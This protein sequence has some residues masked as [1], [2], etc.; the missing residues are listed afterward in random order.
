MMAAWCLN[1]AARL[2]DSFLK[3]HP[4]QLKSILA[5]TKLKKKECVDWKTVARKIKVPLDKNRNVIA[6]FDGF[7]RLKS[8]PQPP[9][10][11]YGMPGFPQKIPVGELGKTQF[12]KQADI[13]ML[14]HL[15]PNLFTRQQALD[16]YHLYEPLT[17][18]KSSLSA[19]VH[20]VVASN[21]GL[22]ERAFHYFQI[23]ANT[24]RN[25]IYGNTAEGIHAAVLGGTWQAVI[26]GFCGIR[27]TKSIL[28]IN[29]S[30]P[31]TWQKIKTKLIYQEMIVHIT[32]KQDEITIYLEPLKSKAK[33][34]YKKL[35]LPVRVFGE[36]HKLAS[37]KEYR[38][39]RRPEHKLS[40]YEME[41]LL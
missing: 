6:Q 40:H 27:V 9:L 38:F 31:S 36:I 20:S 35:H 25:N 1:T 37:N 11:E 39:E 4:K 32:A 23:S 22:K 19:S 8:L 24:D 7:F 34:T 14:I 41:G 26:F 33:Q 13:V 29:P 12:I 17:L 2:V 30:I 15:L 10:D 18:H 28:G 3:S 5:T 21:L 16:N